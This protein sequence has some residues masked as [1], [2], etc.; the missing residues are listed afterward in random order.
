MVRP[1]T[2]HAVLACAQLCARAVRHHHTSPRARIHQSLA[3]FKIG[4]CAARPLHAPQAL[5]SL[6]NNTSIVA[7]LEAARVRF[8]RLLR[9]GAHVHHY[10]EFMDAEAFHTAAETL[11]DVI[12]SYREVEREG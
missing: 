2:L 6:S 9:A 5:L 7:T 12:S 10:T 1:P 3:G 4:I 8:T 11:A